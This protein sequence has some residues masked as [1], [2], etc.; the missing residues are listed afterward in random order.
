MP[1]E[2]PVVSVAT[3]DWASVVGDKGACFQICIRTTKSHKAA[4]PQ[5]I[6]S[7]KSVTRCIGSTY[8]AANTKLSLR[9][10][11]LSTYHR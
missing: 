3:T 11:F 10:V 2:D 8:T 6:S 7:L 1:V 9:R 5:S 4:F